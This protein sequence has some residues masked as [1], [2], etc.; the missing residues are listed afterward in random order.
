MKNPQLWPTPQDYNETIQNPQICFEDSDLRQ[1]KVETTAIGLPRSAS[2]TFASVYKIK[3]PKANW[4]VRCFLSNRTDQEERYQQISEFVLFD[5]LDCT[6]E[7]Q[8]LAKG[9]K[10][11]SNWYPIV[12]MPWIDGPTLENYLHDIIDNREKLRALSK[13]FYELSMQLERAGIAHGDLQH[14]N[15]IV[16][17]NGLRLVDYDAFYVPKLLGKRNL[18]YG[19]P[20]YQHPMRDDYHFDVS[21]DNFSSWLIHLSLTAL[22]LEPNLFKEFNGGDDCILFKRADLLE[23]ESSELFKLLDSHKSEELRTISRRLKGMLWVLPHLVPPLDASEE[24]LAHLPTEK[25]DSLAL[26]LPNQFEGTSAPEPHSKRSASS[27]IKQRRASVKPKLKGLI[28]MADGVFQNAAKHVSPNY[29][30]TLR[31]LDGNDCL[32][33]GDY[34]E[35]HKC[36]SEVREIHARAFPTEWEQSLA[37]LIRLAMCSNYLDTS[38]RAN[39]YCLLAAQ[40]AKERAK[41]YEQDIARLQSSRAVMLSKNLAYLDHDKKTVESL[42]KFYNSLADFLYYIGRKSADRKATAAQL[43]TALMGSSVE[44]TNKPEVNIVLLPLMQLALSLLE[45]GGFAGSEIAYAEST[46][47]LLWYSGLWHTTNSWSKKQVDYHAFWTAQCKLMKALARASEEPVLMLRA[48]IVSRAD[49]TQ[50]EDSGFIEFCMENRNSLKSALFDCCKQMRGETAL[51]AFG[52]SL[53]GL[54]KKNLIQY[55]VA[56]TWLWHEV[57][58]TSA[59]TPLTRMLWLKQ[60]D[61]QIVGECLDDETKEAVFEALR[62]N[63]QIFSYGYFEELVLAVRKI[64]PDHAAFTNRLANELVKQVKEKHSELSE[65][66]IESAKCFVKRY[67]GDDGHLSYFA[68]YYKKPTPNVTRIRGDKR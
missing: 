28:K 33:R 39:N 36:F 43:F 34:E 35:A 42:A 16:S 1:G 41:E 5:Q 50:K 56:V 6:I 27:I 32:S 4:A 62:S 58:S 61:K 17:P 51:N 19:H 38:T 65:D 13:D 53:R 52:P 68:E 29:Y 11:G 46:K 31:T 7:F 21:V 63:V 67:A 64:D 66:K 15:I 25:P 23:P 18:E 40:T 26:E 2:G 59:V 30:I 54:R 37:L 44:T 9:I 12:K 49:G 47:S 22:I 3:T 60:F 24:D 55:Q 20:N 10:I 45:T 8:Y 14:G 57:V 48:E